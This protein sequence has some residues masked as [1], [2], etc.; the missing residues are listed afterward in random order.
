MAL[1][2]RYLWGE[3]VDELLAQ[4]DVTKN[5]TATDRVL[6]P[7]VDQLGTVRD[8]VKQDGTV[9]T[10]F[11]YT[12]F[13]EVESGDTSL[14]RYLFTSREFDVD[15]GLQYNRAR[16]YDA[17]TGRWMSEDP[18]GFAAGDANTARYVGN[19]VVDRFDPNGMWEWPWSENASWEPAF[20][21][22][23]D[24]VFIGHGGDWI[25][26]NFGGGR[27]GPPDMSG[28]LIGWGTEI[29]GFAPIA[30][31]IKDAYEVIMGVDVNGNELSPWERGLT[32]IGLMVPL[33]PGS[34]IRGGGEAVEHIDDVADGVSDV[35]DA[36]RRGGGR[37]DELED[38]IG[39]CRRGCGIETC[40]VAGTLV[41][42][43]EAAQST[44]T[45]VAE[46]PADEIKKASLAMWEP[47]IVA[48]GVT[49]FGMEI[50][51][52]RRRQRRRINHKRESWWREQDDTGLADVDAIS[53]DATGEFDENPNDAV[54]SDMSAWWTD[55]VR[56]NG[57]TSLSAPPVGPTVRLRFARGLL[58]LAASLL[59]VGMA[60]WWSGESRR[61]A[62][63]DHLRPAV[64]STTSAPVSAESSHRGLVPI[65]ALRVG[66]RVL[67]DTP[68]DDR[69]AGWAETS[70]DPA[71]WRK[72]S[73]R[74]E[75]EWPDGT[76]DDINVE[77]L[78]PP[79][80]IVAHDAH[81]GRL[82]PI[83]L[84]LVEMGLPKGLKARVLDNLP[85][86]PIRPGPG[87]VVLTTVNHLNRYVFELRLEDEH[88]RQTTVRPTGFHKFY[89][90]DRRE[91]VSAD[92]VDEGER[93]TALGGTVRLIS[94]RR[95]PGAHR[96]YN[97][98]VEGEH[99]YHVTNLVVDGHNTGC[100]PD[101]APARSIDIIP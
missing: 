36:V 68:D 83:P 99:V 22:F 55:A 21:E 51:A 15:T 60:R 5:L 75:V 57:D 74:A 89:S 8:L 33:V 16:W 56:P 77:T 41:A 52:G 9:A 46:S 19:G 98:T 69:P 87:R 40:F 76:V 88:G 65:E 43:P 64:V 2:R 91:W 95:I 18:L 54:L 78:Q 32:V 85:C 29:A 73:L 20:G 66:D 31:E 49:A 3:R 84:D 70:V 10:Q 4:E 101:G 26:R 42:V 81:V 23:F 72:L 58:W 59:L 37:V 90:A 79:E 48:A 34:W 71:T 44:V 12:S 39:V 97:L 7:V 47:I 80:W 17:A 11:V 28:R 100:G 94:R 93:L 14:T 92:S 1:V 27:Y 35:I 53:S 96:V 25:D 13:G 6:W 63:S 61:P 24:D 62:R 67:A 86:P 38:G 50:I 82:V 30:G 45:L